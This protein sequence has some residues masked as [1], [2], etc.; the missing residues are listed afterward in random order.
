MES[1]L[2]YGSNVELPPLDVL[3]WSNLGT[4]EFS[5]ISKIVSFA[6]STCRCQNVE[7]PNKKPNRHGEICKN[8][9]SIL[10]KHINHSAP[11]R[12]ASR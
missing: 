8:H 3:I 12:V 6:C 11:I 9:V 10:L 5:I 4:H 7:L 1:S 2:F